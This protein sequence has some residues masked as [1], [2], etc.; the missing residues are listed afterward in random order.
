MNALQEM[1]TIRNAIAHWQNI[2][3]EKFQ[4]LVRTK[5]STGTYPKG[6]TIGAFLTGIIPRS[7]PPETFFDSYVARVRFLAGKIVPG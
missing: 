4:A 7:A 2:P 3:Q 5:S 6:L 1:R